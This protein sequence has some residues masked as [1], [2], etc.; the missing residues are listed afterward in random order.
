MIWKK[1]FNRVYQKVLWCVLCVA[2]VPKWLVKVVPA[3]Y[4]GARSRTC[5]ITSFIEDSEI[6]V[7]VH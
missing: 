7:G 3:M 2:G 1:A 5:I 6:K 4:V